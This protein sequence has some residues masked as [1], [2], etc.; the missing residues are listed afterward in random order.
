MKKAWKFAQEGGLGYVDS[1]NWGNQDATL[2]VPHKNCKIQ[3]GH[4]ETR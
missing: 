1:K 3:N 2:M 4:Q